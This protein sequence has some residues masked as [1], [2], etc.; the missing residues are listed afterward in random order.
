MIYNVVTMI[1]RPGMMDDFLAEA[2]KIRPVV[3]AEKGCLMYDYT[4]EIERSEGR[5]EP[6]NPDRITLYEKW[7]SQADLDTHSATAHMKAFIDTVRP[8]RESVLIRTGTE[9][10]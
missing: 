2:K 8:L 4:R 9:A 1:I 10:F 3:L 6:M 7:A 5:Q